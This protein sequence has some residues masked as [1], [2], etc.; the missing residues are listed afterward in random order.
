MKQVYRYLSQT[1]QSYFLFG[2]RGTGKTTWLKTNYP[3]AYYIDL[4]S[5][6]L[7]ITYSSNPERLTEIVEG[8]PEKKVFI[9]D[10][11]QRIPSILT[12]VHQLI[13]EKKELQF[14][15]TGSSARK[16]KR[17]GTDLLAGR[18][19]LKK[20]HPF[21]AA[22]LGGQFMLE[23][24][25][26][27]GMLPLVI[28]STKPNEVLYSYAALYIRE[29]VQSEG[30]VRNIGSFSR[31]LEA[32]SFS[33]GSI[34][35][36]S[37]VAR[38]CSVERK[39]VEAY[40][41]ILEDL[42]LGY[43]LPIFTKRAKR[44]LISHS[45]FYFCD[46]GVFQSLRPKGPLD[47]INEISGQAIEGLVLQHLTAWIDYSNIYEKVYYW[48]TKSGLEVDFII[49]G[50]NE[51]V[52]IEVKNSDKVKSK[53]LKGL[54]NFNEDYPEARLLFLYRGTE[55]IKKGN[56]LIIPVDI[57]LKQ[58]VPNKPLYTF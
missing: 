7:F 1:N 40:I 28:A 32:I 24:A 35:N 42:L 6:K 57:F 45:K 5:T 2:P 47:N 27:L 19:L 46:S 44:I 50:E 36:V 17:T 34:L 10:E 23:S 13:E 29:E 53:E 3:D 55:K 20:C 15:L 18:A 48:R 39:T 37:E 49:Y 33:H 14:I 8:N 31:F 41:S 16:L 22:E 9:I 58:L 56:I 26:K 30:L 12:I 54:K 51:F 25:L 21:I 52:A 4:L 43:K 38:E 11:V